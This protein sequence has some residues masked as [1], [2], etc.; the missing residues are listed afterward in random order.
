MSDFVVYTIPGS[1]FARAVMAVLEEKREPWRLAPLAPGMAKQEPHLSRQPFGR[2]PVLEQE[3]FVLYETQAIVRYLDRV[4]PDPPLTPVDA[5]AAARMDQV[6]NINDWH[7]FQGCGNIIGFQRVV[8]PALLGLTPDEDAIAEAM[9]RAHVV[10]AELSRL[11]G[12]Q[13]YFA[14][15][16]I[17]LAD[18]LVAPQLDF[19]AATPEWATLTA[20]NGNLVEWLGRLNARPSMQSTTWR[21]VAELAAAA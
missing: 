1:P 10:F 3:G 13:G 18:L 2:M 19:L 17:S 15:E 14:G 5:R 7:L 8:G 6:M 16:R 9:P 12:Q 4:L 11:L 20:R 21:K